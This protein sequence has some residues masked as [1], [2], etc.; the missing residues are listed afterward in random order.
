MKSLSR[1]K[2]DKLYRYFYGYNNQ[3]NIAIEMKEKAIS[4]GFKNAFIVA[5]LNGEKISIEKALKN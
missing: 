5:Y 1:E 2:S 4:S 3:Y